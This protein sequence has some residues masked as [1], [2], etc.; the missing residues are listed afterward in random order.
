M[1]SLVGAANMKEAVYSGAN[2]SIEGWYDYAVWRKNPG[3][4]QPEML[5]SGRRLD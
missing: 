5:V 1:W 2:L 4:G 3:T